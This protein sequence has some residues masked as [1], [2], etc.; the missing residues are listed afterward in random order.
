MG[1]LFNMKL[2]I[3]R[4][5]DTGINEVTN[6]LL[7]ADVMWDTQSLV[8]GKPVDPPTVYIKIESITDSDGNGL[9]H[10]YG[11]EDAAHVELE[12]AFREGREE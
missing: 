2:S 5:I 11:V 12:K 6:L 10:L 9:E 8:D 7:V 1:D 3:I 4:P